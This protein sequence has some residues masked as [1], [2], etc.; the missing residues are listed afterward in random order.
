MTFNTVPKIYIQEA[1]LESSFMQEGA[2]DLE[3][4]QIW[5]PN[6]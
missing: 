2:R 3:K 5:I 1:G 6:F 4:T